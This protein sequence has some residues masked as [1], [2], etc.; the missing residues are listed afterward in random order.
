MIYKHHASIFDTRKI[1]GFNGLNNLGKFKN[2]YLKISKE[3]FKKNFIKSLKKKNIDQKN[4]IDAIHESYQ[5]SINNK[6]KYILYHVHAID[7]YSR[8]LKNDFK[9]EKILATTRHPT[10]NFWRRAYADDKIDQ[11]RYDY[12]DYENLK[13]YRYITRLRDLY[14]QFLHCD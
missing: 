9:N 2:G 10:Y 7:T 11:A 4:L 12:T 1:K 3:K 13:N 14:L 5:Y 8:Y 6:K